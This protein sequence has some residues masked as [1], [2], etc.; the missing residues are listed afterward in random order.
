MI[1]PTGGGAIPRPCDNGRVEHRPEPGS[2]PDT[3]GSYQF[4]DARGRIL[5]VG[6]ATSL[7]SRLGSYFAPPESLA[8]RTRQ[9]LDE[10]R[11]HLSYGQYAKFR[12]KIRKAA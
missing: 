10:H 11:G 5:Y 8:P 2:I 6:K 7:R 9:M 4:K 3:P 12:G 1:T